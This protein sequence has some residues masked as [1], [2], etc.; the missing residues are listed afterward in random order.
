MASQTKWKY[1][2]FCNLEASSKA[3][4]HYMVSF[5]FDLQL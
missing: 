4:K 2:F 1:S 5:Q 3:I